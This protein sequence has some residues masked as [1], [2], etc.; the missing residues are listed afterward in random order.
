[1][2]S[3]DEELKVT[4][5]RNMLL[6]LWAAEKLGL[7]GGKAEAYAKELALGTLDAA[8]SDVFKTIRKDFDAA[9]VI[10]SDEQLLDVMESFMLQAS[11]QVPGARSGSGVDAAEVAL[12]R[13]LT[14]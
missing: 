4:V 9:G 12:K 8:R 10:Q 14:R 1:M 5:R 6:G 13:K 3:L 2:S 7:A 11:A